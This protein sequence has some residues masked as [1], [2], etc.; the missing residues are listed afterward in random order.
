[1][2]D[3]QFK[4]T[5][6]LREF[7]EPKEGE[8]VELGEGLELWKVPLSMLQEQSMNARSMTSDTFLQL[9]DNIRRSNRMESL[10]LIAVQYR[11]KGEKAKMVLE[12]VSGHHRT[13]AA[14]KAGLDEIWAL[15]DVSNLTRDRVRAKQ[16]AHNSIS[17]TDNPDL[18][19]QI[20]AQIAN[21]DARVEAFIEPDLSGLASTNKLLTNEFNVT[22]EAKV[23]SI[24]FLPAQ[25]KIFEEAIARLAATDTSEVYLAALDEY[26]TLTAAVG[27]VSESYDIRSTPTIFAKMA[28]IVLDH[29][30]KQQPEVSEEEKT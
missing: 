27:A 8:R 14:R 10:P 25:K 7:W 24:L 19:A 23:V 20:F 16:L 17:G 26:E 6:E 12:V 29:I 3:Q 4:T 5:E 21:V 1:M 30:A 9:V 22:L 11:G 13:R 28:E 2:S 15:V 18:V